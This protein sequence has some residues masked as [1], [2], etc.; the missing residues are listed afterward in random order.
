MRTDTERYGNALVFR[1]YQNFMARR[2]RLTLAETDAKLT[3]KCR[4]LHPVFGDLVRGKTVLDLGSNAGFFSFWAADCGATSVTALDISEINCKGAARGARM[5]GWPVKVI[6]AGVEQCDTRA[7]VV[8][9]LSVIHWLCSPHVQLG[10]F[11]TLDRMIG[12][13]AGLARETLV[14]E[15]MDLEDPTIRSWKEV[16]NTYTKEQFL[17]ALGEHFTSIKALPR[18]ASTRQIY[19]ASKEAS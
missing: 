10:Q 6:A 19:I 16:R 17:N 13:L 7:D 3:A 14:V 8:L 15:W 12:H 9:A 18:T 11:D 1:G 2:G 5:F 4:A